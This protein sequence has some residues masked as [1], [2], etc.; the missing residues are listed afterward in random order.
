MSGF[1]CVC[2][3]SAARVRVWLPTTVFPQSKIV[4]ACEMETH[5]KAP[6]YRDMIEHGHVYPVKTRRVVTIQIFRPSPS[7]P[8]QKKKKVTRYRPR[9]VHCTTYSTFRRYDLSGSLARKR[10]RGARPQAP[11]PRARRPGAQ[12]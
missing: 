10:N 3:C 7:P 1:M 6:R 8:P 11:C 12:T 4:G 9:A 2:A 5:M